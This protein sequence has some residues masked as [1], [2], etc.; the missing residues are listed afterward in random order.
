MTRYEI[1]AHHEEDAG[2]SGYRA[3]YGVA[4]YEDSSLIR[5]V[6]DVCADADSIRALVKLFNVE[7]L[8]PIH[9]SQAVEDYL[10]DHEIP[11]SC[12]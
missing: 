8:D 12:E 10:T 9:L 2:N 1:L 5:V 3:A 7:G 4:V 6:R 11:R